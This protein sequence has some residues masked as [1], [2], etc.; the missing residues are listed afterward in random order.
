MKMIT[1]VALL[2][3]VTSLWS[4]VRV[5]AQSEAIRTKRSEFRIPFTFE[6]DEYERLG[7]QEV[8]LFLSMDL[9]ASWQHVQSA[10]PTSQK[11]RYKTQRQGEHWFAV[12]TLDRNRQLHPQGKLT[13]GLKVVVDT[14]DPEL[15]MRLAEMDGSQV[16]VMWQATDSDLDASSMRLEYMEEGTGKWVPAEFTPS[17]SG[18]AVIATVG[19]EK[20]TVRL[21]MRDLAGNVG[22][23]ERVLRLKAVDP[24]AIQPGRLD[25]PVEPAQTTSLLVSSPALPMSDA[26][27]ISVAPPVIAPEIPQAAPA[28]VQQSPVLPPTPEQ[29]IGP[30]SFPP[31]T[32]QP[33]VA[34]AQAPEPAPFQLQTRTVSAP[35]APARSMIDLPLLSEVQEPVVSQPT[36]PAP[37]EEATPEPEID[38]NLPRIVNQLQF[39]LDYALEDLGPSGLSAVEVF[40]TEDGGKKWWRYGEDQDKQS[41]VILRVPRDGTYGFMIAAKSGVGLG[42]APPSPGEAPHAVVVVDRT[43]PKAR[44]DRI[45]MSDDGRTMTVNWKTADGNAHQRPVR[46]EYAET[47]AGP[48]TPMGDWQQDSGEMKWSVAKGVPS[49]I[50]VRMLVRDAADNMGQIVYPQSVLVDMSRPRARITNVKISRPRQ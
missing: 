10:L 14:T 30:Y 33:P 27:V 12:R 25:A 39:R 5:E 19:G 8:Q 24:I 31:D 40:I 13:P 2:I 50:H 41:P 28:P 38:P 17:A 23:A 20:V 29:V 42:D 6:K 3:F 32:Q 48:W 43:P 34:Q 4:P 22:V 1:R 26:P 16:K 18:E 15:M 7:V 44:F 47:P 36:P 37:V 35:I 46:M 21:G 49:R 11:F 9:G 45:A